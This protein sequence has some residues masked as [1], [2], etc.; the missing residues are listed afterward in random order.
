MPDQIF[1][2]DFWDDQYKQQKQG[3]DI[4]YP[5]TPLKEYIDQ[6]TDKNIRILIPGC[7]NGYE[8]EYLMQQ[9]FQHLTVIDISSVLTAQ[10]A[11][12]LKTYAGNSLNII[13]GDF[14]EH[15][16][17][18]DLIL[19]QTFFCVFPPAMR[20]KYAEKVKELLAPG[21]TIA[22]VLF[23]RDFDSAPPYGG[24]IESYMPIFQQQLRLKKM[25]PCRNSIKPRQ[26]AEAFFIA[27]ND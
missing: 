2:A 21:G 25:E 15:A 8:A 11:E 9:G 17:Q 20:P 22:G 6:L 7:G 23:N 14:F 13:T 24:H 5:S 4:G 16:G 10:L 12:R 19:E 18:Y 26:G 1:D 3:W 27:I